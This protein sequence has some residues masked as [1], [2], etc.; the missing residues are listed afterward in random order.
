MDAHK[1]KIAAAVGGVGLVA[2][3]FIRRHAAATAAANSAA[4]SDNGAASL[5][6]YVSSGLGS[7]STGVST[8]GSY[9]SYSTGSSDS[10]S[11]D[12]NLNPTSQTNSTVSNF[13]QLLQGILKSSADASA[14]AQQ[15]VAAN[16][17]QATQAIQNIAPTPAAVPA[18]SA[19]PAQ[20][21][22][23]GPTNLVNTAG[24]YLVAN[25][26]LYASDT[27]YRNA[28]N[29]VTAANQNR[30]GAGWNSVASGASADELNIELSDQ[31]NPNWRNQQAG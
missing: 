13:A 16:N 6:D 3:I 14:A 2:V 29:T 11:S 24:G 20:P 25:A 5:S 23:T 9:A 30:F 4:S 22:Y 19:A 8:G 27:T 17:A 1:L 28:W 26:G 7:I 18:S 10:G 21:A 15:N 12:A 31:I